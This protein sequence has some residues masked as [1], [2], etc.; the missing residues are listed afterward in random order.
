[1]T[2]TP[3]TSVPGNGRA[4]PPDGAPVTLNRRW[5]QWQA[6]LTPP[7]APLFLRDRH[8]RI[9]VVGGGDIG[10]RNAHSARAAPNAAIAAIC[11]LNPDI[12]RTMAREFSVPAVRDYADL[13]ARDDVD[14]VLLSLPH[15]L[16]APLAM[17]AAAAGKHVLLE[18]PLGVSLDDATRIVRACEQAGVRLSVNFSFRYRPAVQL[19]RQFIRDELLGEIAGLQISFYHFKGA[20]YWAGGFTGRASGD[21]RASKDKAGGGL[22]ILTVCHE[23]DYARYCTGLDV[24]RVYSEYGTF[25]AKVEVEDAIAVTLHLSN[26][27]IGSVTASSHW[28]AEPLD[29]L[30]IWGTHGALRLLASSQLSLWSERRWGDLAAGQEHH[31]TRFPAVDYTARWIDAVA[32]A[33]AQGEPPAITGIDGWINNA[34]IEAAYQSRDLGRAVDVPRWPAHEE[35]PA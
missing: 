32:R 20:R 3:D 30:R 24:T 18:K 11:D 23:L 12:R 25:G 33:I 6:A 5:F 29:E 9:G 21:W 2:D 28:R 8:L 13:L 17:Q 7:P 34:V 10:L 19:A 15:H 4:T 27:A 31:I 1:M 35:T 22:L 26:G 16:H 14:A